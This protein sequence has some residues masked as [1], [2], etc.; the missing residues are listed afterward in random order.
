[1]HEQCAVNPSLI[2]IGLL[3]CSAAGSFSLIFTLQQGNQDK[4]FGGSMLPPNSDVSVEVRW[5]PMRHFWYLS[6]A[7]SE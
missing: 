1:V 5:A 3:E 2:F 4:E 6:I 7:P